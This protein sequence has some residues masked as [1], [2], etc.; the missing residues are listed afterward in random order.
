[1]HPGLLENSIA[2]EEAV[3]SWSC[4][5]Q[6]RQAAEQNLKDL[7][8]NFESVQKKLRTIPEHAHAA[9]DQATTLLYCIATEISGSGEQ[10][11]EREKLEH[12][13]WQAISEVQYVTIMAS[14]NHLCRNFLL[15]SESTAADKKKIVS[16]SRRPLR[17]QCP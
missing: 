13:L 7:V 5:R 12:R 3:I 16:L 1:V 11:T 14:F 15:R 8:Q 6:Q 4:V 10:S 9:A 2:A 17:T